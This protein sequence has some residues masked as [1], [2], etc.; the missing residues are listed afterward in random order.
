[1]AEQEE[2]GAIVNVGDWAIARPY[3]EYGAYFVSKSTIPTM[4]RMFAVELAPRVFVGKRLCDRCL[5][6]DRRGTD[7]RR[8]RLKCTSPLIALRSL[9]AGVV[10]IMRAIYKN[11]FA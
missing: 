9:F 8:D 10:P 5:P 2:G 3:R 6:A 11:F 7:D 1:M 4:T